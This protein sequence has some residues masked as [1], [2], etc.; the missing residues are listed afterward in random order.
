MT[1]RR[2]CW[3]TRSSRSPRTGLAFK[4]DTDKGL[5]FAGKFTDISQPFLYVSGHRG[6]LFRGQG[7]SP[8]VILITDGKLEPKKPRSVEAAYNDIL[9][10]LKEKLSGVP[11]YTIGLGDKEIHDKFLARGERVGFLRDQLAAPTGG[12]FFHARSVNQLIEIY[13]KILRIT[14]GASEIEGKFA[15]PG[16]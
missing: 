3:Q 16:G 7:Y 1:S 14:T 9:E 8:A 10:S 11:F 15:V 4:A 6:E 13:L 12:R 2:G 5:T